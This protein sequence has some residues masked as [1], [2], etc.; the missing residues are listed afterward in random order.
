MNKYRV[1]IRDKS[2]D[3]SFTRKIY[4]CGPHAQRNYSFYNNPKIRIKAAI[5]I[6]KFVRRILARRKYNKIGDL[7]QNMASKALEETKI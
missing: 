6:Q 1:K 5:V 2:C 4:S 7:F 3:L